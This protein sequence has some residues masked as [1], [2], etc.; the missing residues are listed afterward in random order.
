[1]KSTVT[2]IILETLMPPIL[3]SAHF[4]GQGTRKVVAFD[5]KVN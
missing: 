2:V 4:C 5:A 3:Y 1:M